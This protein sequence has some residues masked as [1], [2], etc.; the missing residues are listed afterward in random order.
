M[1]DKIKCTDL[2]AIFSYPGV[3]ILLGSAVKSERGYLGNASWIRLMISHHKEHED[4]KEKTHLF[5]VSFR[6]LSA[7]R[8]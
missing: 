4:H 1:I 7:L 5:T 2:I 3:C 8:G 6:V